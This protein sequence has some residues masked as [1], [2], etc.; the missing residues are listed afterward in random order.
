MDKNI[1]NIFNLL[2][3]LALFSLVGDTLGFIIKN[4]SLVGD[5]L[6]FSI[7]KIFKLSIFN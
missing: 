2:L 7:K 4:F 3:N 1:K 6:G 5:T